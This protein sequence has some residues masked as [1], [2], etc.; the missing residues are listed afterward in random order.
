MTEDQLREYVN[1]QAAKYA[2]LDNVAIINEEKLKE[3]E[4]ERFA[5]VNTVQ[6]VDLDK[7]YGDKHWFN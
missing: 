6:A 2:Y 1:K 4:Q 7:L 5:V 3:A